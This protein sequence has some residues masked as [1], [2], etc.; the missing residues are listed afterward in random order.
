MRTQRRST[1]AHIPQQDLWIAWILA[2]LLAFF[3]SASS[4][5]EC[6]MSKLIDR[7]C[8]TGIERRAM[9]SGK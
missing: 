2:C 4:L 7:A 5:L 3:V 6:M 9:S 1:K 8:G